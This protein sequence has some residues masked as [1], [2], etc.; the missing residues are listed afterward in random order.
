MF[1]TNVELSDITE[2]VLP[3]Q[4]YSPSLTAWSPKVLM[5]TVGAERPPTRSGQGEH[6]LK[7]GLVPVSHLS[8]ETNLTEAKAVLISIESAPKVLIF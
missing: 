3:F 7:L 6:L 1:N 2:L 5:C 8:L 4:N